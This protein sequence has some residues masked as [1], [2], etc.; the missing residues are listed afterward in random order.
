M[1]AI[2]LNDDG[3]TLILIASHEHINHRYFRRHAPPPLS[4]HLPRYH[5]IVVAGDAAPSVPGDVTRERES[6]RE[7]ERER[8]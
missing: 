3:T 2:R 8:A 7:R 4:F 5:A 6:E 1:S